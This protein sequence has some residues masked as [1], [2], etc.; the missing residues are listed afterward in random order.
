MFR[1][2]FPFLL[3]T[4]LAGLV[5]D[6]GLYTMHRLSH[7]VFWLWRLHAV[8]H[9]A[10]RLYALN[11]ERRHPLHFLLEGTPGLLAAG[12]LGAPPEAMACFLA[13]F[14][15]HLFLQHGNLAYR[16]GWL[17]YLFAVAENHRWHH[18]KAHMES[19]VNF[20][21]FFALW[22]H[23]FGTAFHQTGT[24]AADGV[25]IEE[26]PDFPTTYLSQLTYH[27]EANR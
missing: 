16:A 6:L 2:L 22:D 19:Q 17:R 9:G 13:V 8:H 11:G 5:V 15:I 23:L 25:G 12:L 10:E 7:T 27:F 18:R 3:Q 21:G 14:H 26:A 24:V 1:R 4:L 20:R